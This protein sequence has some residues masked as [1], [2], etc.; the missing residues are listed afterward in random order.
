MATDP[1]HPPICDYEGSDYQT[2]FWEQGGRAYEDG[3]EAVALRRLLP[4]HGQLM[5]EVGA[6]AGRNTPRYAGYE[7]IVVMDYSTTQLEQ[8]QQYLGSSERYI[9]VAADVYKLPFVDG[10]FDGATIIRVLHHMADAPAALQQVR[11]TLQP[12]ATLILEYA[13]KRNLK[14][15][16]R[17]LLDRQKWSP[18]SLE[19]VEYIPL[20][21]DFHPKAINGWL[22]QLG[23]A[24]ERQL[25]VSH[26]RVGWLKRH[27][28]TRLLVALDALFQPLG[29]LWK[30]T[31]SIFVRAR[32]AASSSVAAPGAFFKCPECGAPLGAPQGKGL[33]CA[34]GR[35]WGIH[36]GIYNFKQASP[37]R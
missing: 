33:Q 4:A 2:R 5:L 37:T 29:A 28:P 9:Y 26:F 31:P 8:A 14:S 30:Y 11:N 20:N 27:V 34:C 35:H 3:A 16:L 18:F 10:L 21:F 24:I 1:Q 7:R 17:W 22:R 23:F 32:A 19:P 25:A 12:Q 13:N 6:G 36:N 15:I